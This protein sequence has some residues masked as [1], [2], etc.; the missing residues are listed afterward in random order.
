MEGDGMIYEIIH[1]VVLKL[2]KVWKSMKTPGTFCMLVGD[3]QQYKP[4]ALAIG[5]KDVFMQLIIPRP[6]E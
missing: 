2:D 5:R 3:R 6:L 4:V 1:H